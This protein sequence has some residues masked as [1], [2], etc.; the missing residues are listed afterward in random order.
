MSRDFPLVMVSG[1]RV[2]KDFA[3]VM[4]GLSKLFVGQRPTLRQGGAEGVDQTARAVARTLGWQVESD[5]KPRYDAPPVGW[6]TGNEVWRQVAPLQ[7][8]EDMLDGVN[9]PARGMWSPVS[10]DVLVVFRRGPELRKG[11]TGHAVRQARRRRIPIVVFEYPEE[12]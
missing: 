2:F 1:P 12:A 11:G 3:P 6:M 10:P 5:W 4:E 8:T 9:G 7:R